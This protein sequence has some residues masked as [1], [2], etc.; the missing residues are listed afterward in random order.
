MTDPKCSWFRSDDGKT[1]LSVGYAIFG[2]K[3]R[4]RGDIV[5]FHGT[6]GSRLDGAY[7]DDAA[8]ALG[9]RIVSIDRP[10]TGMYGD[11]HV[12]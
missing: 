11:C 3:V 5:F 9:V 7:L 8:S 6:P 12:G 1:E 2:R 10:G 4:P